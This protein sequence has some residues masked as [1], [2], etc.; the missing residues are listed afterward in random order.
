MKKRILVLLSVVALMVV[1]LAMP[2]ASGVALAEPGGQGI[3]NGRGVG[4]GDN[5][6]FD[7]GNRFGIAKGEGRHNNPHGCACPGG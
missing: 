5:H 3:G 6:Q 2:L 7:S 4:G 1:M